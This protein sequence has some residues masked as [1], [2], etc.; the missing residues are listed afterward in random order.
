MKKIYL[1]YFGNSI[2]V[3]LPNPMK[4]AS[5]TTDEKFY[6]KYF[7]VHNLLTTNA[8][9]KTNMQWDDILTQS[10]NQTYLTYG[11][12]LFA[13]NRTLSMEEACSFR[14]SWGIESFDGAESL[15]TY[16]W[17]IQ[18]GDNEDSPVIFVKT[19]NYNYSNVYIKNISKMLNYL[20]EHSSLTNQ[21]LKSSFL[22]WDMI[23]IK[24]IAEYIAQN[25]INVIGY[26]S[27]DS[28]F[29]RDPLE[30]KIKDRIQDG[31][32]QLVEINNNVKIFL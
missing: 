31:I 5:K 21:L 3:V 11:T 8:D 14:D 12:L 19:D 30:R 1:R 23:D 22:N 6:Y 16:A 24:D 27:I 15:E 9:F 32:S 18:A 10:T 4:Q 13:L 20:L 17:A 7:G 25:G 2:Q 28:S 29:S 26:V